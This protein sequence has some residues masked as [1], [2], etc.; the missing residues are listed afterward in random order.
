M[1][2]QSDR[3]EPSV[4]CS[5]AQVAEGVSLLVE[6]WLTDGYPN[7]IA[8]VYEGFANDPLGRCRWYAHKHDWKR[9]SVLSRRDHLVIE[10]SHSCRRCGVAFSVHADG[11]TK[12]WQVAL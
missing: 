11:T 1:T 8:S 4:K 10:I 9:G 2:E 12:R 5:K 7:V 3:L 6:H